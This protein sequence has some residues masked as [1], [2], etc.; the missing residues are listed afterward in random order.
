MKR[1]VNKMKNRILIAD[2]DWF[3]LQLLKF[4][5]GKYGFEV[6]TANNEKELWK[7]AFDSEPDLILIDLLL[8]S[9]IGSDVYET[10]IDFG[11]KQDVP[12]VFMSAFVDQ[13]ETIV[14]GEKDEAAFPVLSKL[15]CLETFVNEINSLLDKKPFCQIECQR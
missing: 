8:K 4:K 12:V 3:F 1:T 14:L 7:H 10:M 9:K 11:L 13:Q 5:L 15:C 6:I 2:D